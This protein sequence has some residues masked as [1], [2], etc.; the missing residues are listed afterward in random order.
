M[1]LPHVHG[2]E[3]HEFDVVTLLAIVK[4]PVVDPAQILRQQT[5][6][7]EI[8]MDGGPDPRM[9]DEALAAGEEG[10]ARRVECRVV[11][12]VDGE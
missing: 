12:A 11:T 9:L 4:E 6:F 10:G 3:C 8:A 5:G 1:V 2:V 7:D